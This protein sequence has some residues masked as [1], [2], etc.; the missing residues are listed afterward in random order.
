MK[1]N[2]SGYVTK[3]NIK[4]SDG[5]TIKDGAFAHQDGVQVPLVWQH[6][7]NSVD[8]I[9][10]H[11]ILVHKDDGVYGYALF[12]N[13]TAGTN[14][15]KLVENKDI[16]AMSI[17]AK[18]VKLNGEDVMHGSIKEVSLVISGANPG[19]VIDDVIIAHADGSEE[20]LK[21]QFVIYTDSDISLTELEHSAK[22]ENKEEDKKEDKKEITH[23]EKTLKEI[24]DGMN[25]QEKDVVYAMLANTMD[26][27]IQHG[28]D[29][30]MKKNIFDK[31]D[32]ARGT[33]L[34]HSEVKGIWEA[35]ISAGSLKKA[36]LAHAGTYGIDNIDVLFPD[37][38]N[39]RGNTPEFDK[40]RS[41]W[42]SGVLGSIHKAPFARIKSVYADITQDDARAKGYITG[43]EKME[44]VFPIFKR[45]TDPTTLYKKQKLDRDDIIDIVD[46]N[47]VS[48][49]Y[50]EMRLMLDEELARAILIGDGRAFDAPDKI[51]EDKIRPIY[52]DNDVYALK[53]RLENTV[54]GV[55]ELEAIIR[56][57]DRYKG[58]GN[59]TL[60]TTRA[61]IAN[62][63]LLKDN[64][65][66][67]RFRSLSEIASF[68]GVKSIIDVEVFEGQT[69][70]H[71]TKT[72]DLLCII[73]NLRDYTSGT[74]AGGQVSMF[75]GFDLDFNQHKYLIE[76]RCSGAL[77][78]IKSAIVVE[79]EQAAG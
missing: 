40:R 4:C 15:R 21:N 69:Q 22:D 75:D 53:V 14:A 13:T 55:A 38:K 29:E 33:V 77:N 58:S 17:Y 71:D 18:D 31:K 2:F 48:F 66:Q 72:Y 74:N 70:I 61:N 26:E 51:K 5:K 20:I 9:L 6:M 25:D 3:N 36:I 65:G 11:V 8:N 27:N 30:H 43:N 79:K 49:M 54:S 32:I 41:E 62:W 57:M 50:A 24:F 42:V 12:N 37:A 64:N 16:S 23:A 56:A 35:A 60:Y 63:K 45:T 47:V 19:A 78:K 73:V 1:Y 44:E 10:G 39:A 46:L 68:I 67:Y 34:S 52:S 59:P 76:T 7:H 28:G